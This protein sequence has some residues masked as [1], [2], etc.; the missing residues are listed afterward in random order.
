LLNA[1]QKTNIVE[2]ARC[3]FVKAGLPPPGLR[4][5]PGIFS[6]FLPPFHT[7]SSPFFRPLSLRSLLT[8]LHC[9]NNAIIF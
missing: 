9:K 6:A 7:V 3:I 4:Q 1:A 2:A 5:N 8:L